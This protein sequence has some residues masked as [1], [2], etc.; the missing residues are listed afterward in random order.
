M[1]LPDLVR[2]GNFSQEEVAD[3][4]EAEGKTVDCYLDRIFESEWGSQP[5]ERNQ[6]CYRETNTCA[7]Y[8]YTAYLSLPAKAFYL[9]DGSSM[10]LYWNKLNDHVLRFQIDT[11]LRVTSVITQEGY[12]LDS[13]AG[14]ELTEL[15]VFFNRFF[16]EHESCLTLQ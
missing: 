13:M 14:G 16:Q 8:I 5:I 10:L 9:K 2:K 11:P 15:Y 12:M 7:L 4:L 6:D 1:S 3:F